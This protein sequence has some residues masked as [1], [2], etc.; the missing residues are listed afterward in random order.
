MEVKAK[1]V[2]PHQPVR[3]RDLKL[4]LPVTR[5]T[6]YR[7]SAAVVGHYVYVAGK[8]GKHL[9]NGRKRTVVPILDTVKNSWRWLPCEGPSCSYVFLALYND[10]LYWFGDEV[11]HES[12]LWGVSRFDVN[13]EE[14]EL[15][16]LKGKGPGPRLGCSMHLH[17]RRK[18]LLIFGGKFRSVKQNDVHL[19]DL[20]LNRWV[21]VSVKGQRPA[22]RC[23]HSSWMVEDE[24]Y[25]FGGFTNEGRF[26]RDGLNVL[27]F[28]LNNI[29]TWS[30]VKE[31]KA[32]GI[33]ANTIVIPWGD[34][35]LLLG[36]SKKTASH[37][38][39]KWNSKARTMEEI[40]GFENSTHV[41][42]V[43]AAVT[44]TSKSLLFGTFRDEG[45]LRLSLEVSP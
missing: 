44:V 39:S 37:L 1:L 32:L 18:Q 43:Y 21:D 31:A 16:E 28:G 9:R 26:P 3:L 13:Q 8:I 27:H 24:F 23:E 4:E 38:A 11:W 40:T 29:V 22:A 35:L 2:V 25:M 45:Y 12:G 17:E 10:Y 7:C 20:R 36:G 5:S 41:R 15:C 6:W 34:S 33:M 19:L 14:W 30:N 42:T